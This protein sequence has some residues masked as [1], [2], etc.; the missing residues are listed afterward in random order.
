[1]ET[2][3]QPQ[4]KSTNIPQRLTLR[5]GQQVEIRS[6]PWKAYLRIKS[7]II[8]AIGGEIGKA[9]ATVADAFATTS[10]ENSETGKND[11]VGALGRS[12]IVERI[13][14]LL[15]V[16]SAEV[17]DLIE[18]FVT[19]C[20]VVVSG[21]STATCSQLNFDDLH[22]LDVLKLRNLILE[23]AEVME[24]FETEKNCYRAVWT[25]ITS[26]LVTENNS[27]GPSQTDPLEGAGG[28]PGNTSSTTAMDGD[29]AI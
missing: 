11:W 20:C 8:D 26:L 1:M 27:T 13:P 10:A 12:G 29:Q 7:R 18:E 16:V 15:G 4:V 21:P 25:A 17:D 14:Q 6:L 2:T 24:L 5:S 22:A 9:L 19:G 3:P 23:N 28:L